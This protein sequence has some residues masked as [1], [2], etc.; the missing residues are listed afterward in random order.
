MPTTMPQAVSSSEATVAL[1][2]S[3]AASLQDA[4]QE[5]K[6]LYERS[7]PIATVTYNFGASGAL[8]Q[9]ISQGAPVNVFLSASPS[10]MDVLE[11]KGQTVADSRQDFLK[12]RL[13]LVVPQRD[14]NT[15]RLDTDRPTIESFADLSDV[16]VGKVAIGEPE[17]VPAG[18]YAEELLDGLNLLDSVR[19]KLVLAKS[20]R[21]VLSYVETGNVDA[22]LVYATD[23]QSSGRVRI[24]AYGSSEMHS[25]I[26]YSVAVIRPSAQQNST[27]KDQE[28]AA[29]LDFV[30]LLSTDE[31][32]AIFKK[33]G[34]AQ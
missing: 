21:Q 18:H 6:A 34:F 12:N 5:I 28:Q 10:W 22:G 15:G 8:A 19:S 27:Q 20:V 4:M 14:A 30:D 33:Y 29:A 9:Q 17:S 26:E 7:F 11:Q 1:T 32:I 3:A 2:V 24:V 13:V 16:R 23:A 31:A 25:Q